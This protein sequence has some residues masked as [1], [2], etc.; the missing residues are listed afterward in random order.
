MVF[1]NFF[2]NNIIRIDGICQNLF[3]KLITSSLLL[4]K[5]NVIYLTTFIDY[6]N[7]TPEILKC[8]DFL[9]EIIDIDNT[10]II[11]NIG[12]ILNNADILNIAKTFFKQKTIGENSKKCNK[13]Q[14]L[15]KKTIHFEN[16][17]LFAHMGFFLKSKLI[18]NDCNEI[19]KYNENK[20]KMKKKISLNLIDLSIN[21]RPDI[22]LNFQFS[23]DILLHGFGIFGCDKKCISQIIVTI[24]Q[25]QAIHFNFHHIQNITFDGNDG[26]VYQ[27][28]FKSP[29]LI[30]KLKNMRVDLLHDN[31][32]LNFYSGLI[33]DVSNEFIILNKMINQKTIF[34]EI[35]YSNI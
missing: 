30:K 29:L 19:L 9:R 17:L 10:V 23:C 26:D 5:T 15:L 11:A 27:I 8:Y 12:Y 4:N 7:L 25:S 22:Y 13:L 16:I 33:C 1:S 6:Y 28:L 3:I 14:Y 24:Y 31:E 34:S 21:M 20:E 18:V 2:E 35:Y 32:Y